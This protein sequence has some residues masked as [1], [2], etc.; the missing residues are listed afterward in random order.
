MRRILVVV[1]FACLLL[2]G[3]KVD[4]TV[5]LA[6]HDDGSGFV[7][8]K[9]A[10]DA[11]AVQN[12]EAGG[13]RLEDRVRLGDLQGAGWKVSPWKR[14]PDGS[15]TLSLRK[16][17]ADAGAVA[18]IFAEVNGKE[19]P[20][21][22]VALERDHNV[23]FTRYKLTGVADLSQL[24]AGVAADPEVAAQLTG[25][26]VDLTQIDQQLTQEI[27]DAFRLRVRLELPHGSKELKPEPGKKVSLSTSSTQ[28]DT[29][30]AL[31]L[32]AA[33]VLGV[34]G[35]V[36]LLRGELRGRRR[37]RRGAGRA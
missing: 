35:V 18:A 23:L 12:A 34:L 29:T 16:D 32:L 27:R 14:S 13:G 6:V 3:C 17:F 1:L 31:F 2:A 15:A 33:V 5:T 19:G 11:E 21:R 9:V 30:R 20:L 10:L 28:F 4:T 24:T 26:R 37:R 36:V 7:R 22:G 25:Q 8:I